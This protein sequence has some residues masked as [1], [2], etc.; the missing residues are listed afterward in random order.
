MLQYLAIST[1][2]FQDSK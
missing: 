2:S 1:L